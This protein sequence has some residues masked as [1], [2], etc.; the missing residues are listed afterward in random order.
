MG[1]DRLRQRY[2]FGKEVDRKNQT[3]HDITSLYCTP[4]ENETIDRAS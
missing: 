3:E 1:D 4:P 2:H